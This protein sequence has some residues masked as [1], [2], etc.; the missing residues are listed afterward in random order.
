M[1]RVRVG[2]FAPNVPW[3]TPPALLTQGAQ[4]D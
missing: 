4:L 3:Q 2:G 1:G